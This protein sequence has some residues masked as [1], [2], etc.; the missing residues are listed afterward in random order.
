MK[1]RIAL[2]GAMRLAY[3]RKGLF[4]ELQV[5][6]GLELNNL[7][8]GDVNSLLGKNIDTL[9][10]C[11]LR[12]I[13]CTKANQGNLVTSL[14]STGYSIQCSFQSLLGI[15]FTKSCAF[16]DLCNQ[17]SLVHNFVFFNVYN[18]VYFSK[19]YHK[20]MY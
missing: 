4:L 2:S 11:T 19:S 7:L 8:S 16:S 3:I 6:T 5:S 12:Y 15:N 20:Y 17:F 1:K 18:R 9:A 13:E 14:Y 10:G